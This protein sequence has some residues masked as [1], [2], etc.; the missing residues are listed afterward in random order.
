MRPDFFDGWYQRIRVDGKWLK[1]EQ[2][3]RPRWNAM[4]RLHRDLNG[5]NVLECGP[6]E[7]FFTGK[8]CERG[9]IVKAYEF[10][11]VMV[12]RA[13]W[14]LK[15]QGMRDRVIL[16]P[17]DV[18]QKYALWP[19]GTFYAAVSL[20]VIHHLR[21][22]LMHLYELHRALQPGGVLYIEAPKW[23]SDGVRLRKREN[24]VLGA[25]FIEKCLGRFFG[26]VSV[27]HDW[28][29]TVGNERVMWEAVKC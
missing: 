15:C 19:T 6:A 23:K 24:Y 26:K 21:G 2:D 10:D 17:G 12:A 7:G 11:P 5:C 16:V 28:Q 14:V 25:G 27:V 20:N 4:R 9:A 3:C 1:G 8:V 13:D 29:N 18:E 22:P